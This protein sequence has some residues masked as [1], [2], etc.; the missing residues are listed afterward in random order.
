[1][2]RKSGLYVSR[3]ETLGIGTPVIGDPRIK[4]SEAYPV[5]PGDES[6]SWKTDDIGTSANNYISDYQYAD[7][8]KSNVIAP[9]FMLSSGLGS[10]N[11]TKVDWIH[12]VERCATYQEDGYPAG[13]WRLPTEAEIVYVYNL[14]HDLGLLSNPFYSTS[15]YWA[16]SGRRYYNGAFVA[17]NGNFSSRCVYDLW[18][19]G[20]EPALTGNAAEQW[21]GFMTS[22]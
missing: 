18:Y 6:Q 3:Y 14:A 19:W 20:D 8:N 4:L 2:M 17:G 10:C 7:I 9:K 1:M 15:N 11:G 22:K 16:N 13:R 21:S 5:N 12:N